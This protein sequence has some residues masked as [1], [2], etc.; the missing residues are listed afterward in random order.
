MQPADAVGLFRALGVRGTHTEIET[1]CAPYGYHP[2]SLRLVAGLIVGDLRQ[3]GDIAGATRLDVSGDLVQRQH[4]VLETAYDSLK[5]GQQALLGSISCFR[6]PVRYEA[7][8]ALVATQHSTE[9]Q[10]RKRKEK[11]S[12]SSLLAA[13]TRD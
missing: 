7:L 12:P 2:L 5:H 4:H 13:S 11:S 8:K 3:P 1:A 6:G 10:T 9:A